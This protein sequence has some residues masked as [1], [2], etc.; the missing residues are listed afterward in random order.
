LIGAFYAME[1]FLETPLGKKFMKLHL[2][3]QYFLIKIHE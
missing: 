3:G 2:V 1:K